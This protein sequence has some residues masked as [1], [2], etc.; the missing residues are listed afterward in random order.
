[1]KNNKRQSDVNNTKLYF[2]RNL[3]SISLMCWW[4]WCPRRVNIMVITSAT[5]DEDSPNLSCRPTTTHDKNDLS[6]TNVNLLLMTWKNGTWGIVNE[7]ECFQ[8]F[9]CLFS[10]IVIV[11]GLTSELYVTFQFHFRIF[12]TF[13]RA[14]IFDK[15][16]YPLWVINWY[17]FFSSL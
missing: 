12:N 5:P 11:E 9:V 3:P 17:L 13:Y 6:W 16:V 2:N 10:N 8:Y 14:N 7:Q 15:I 1:M 4:S